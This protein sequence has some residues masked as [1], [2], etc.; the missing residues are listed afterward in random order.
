MPPRPPSTTSEF[1]ALHELAVTVAEAA[2]V[3]LLTHLHGERTIDSKTSPTDA[4][5]EMDRAAEALIVQRL[6][7]ARPDDGLLGEEGA[8]RA[9]TS[10]VRWVIDPLDGTVNYLYRRAAFAVSVAAEVDGWPVAGAIVDPQRGETFHAW[11]G[12]GAW[13][14]GA[15]IH[16]SNV[17][18]LDRALVGTGFD[19]VPE[20]RRRQ[21]AELAE[22]IDVVRDIRRAGSAALDMCA[23]ACGRLDAYYERGPHW[24]DAAAGSLIVREAGGIAEPLPAHARPAEASSADIW[25]AAAPAVA[26]AFRAL[27]VQA[28]RAAEA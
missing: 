3:L 20:R 13:L 5:T 16:T 14:D 25:I 2:G 4:V 27:I 23:V 8:N 17:A 15:R 10:G 9:G 18:T 24:W 26:D 12:G 7:A 21:G 6:L 1:E 22:I 11:L 28:A 19:Y